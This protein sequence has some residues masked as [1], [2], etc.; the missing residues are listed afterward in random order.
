MTK[1]PMVSVVVPAYNEAPCLPRL[2]ESLRLAC[3]PLPFDF[4][5]LFVDD[6]SRDDTAD[7]LDRLAQAD[8]RV[9]PLSLSRNFGHQA[10]LTAGLEHAEGDAVIMMDGDGQHPPEVIPLL[11]D[12]WRDGFEVVNT[13]RLDTAGGSYFKAAC[14]DAFYRVF[15]RLTGL[16][17]SPGSADFRLLDRQALDALNS[18][19]ERHRFIRGLVPWIGFRQAQ[20]EFHAPERFAGRS[21]YT[22]SRSLRLAIEGMTAFSLYPLRLVTMFGW[23][24]M[25]FSM[26]YG[27]FALFNSL[28]TGSVI[29]GWTSLIL[30]VLFFGGGQLV[31]LGIVSEYLGRTLDQVKGRP[32]YLV[33]QARGKPR[34]ALPAPHLRRRL[35]GLRSNADR[36]EA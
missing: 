35:P 3:D 32:V 18:L 26:A 4:E 25:A 30:C 31:A 33:R 21:K 7:V 23:F 8:D 19:P 6:G 34:R 27:L 10:A 2:H 11:L 17:I 14:S 5:F 24:V 20:V 13:V 9:R 29:R 1:R 15:R 12:R 22:F 16:P 36:T 28:V